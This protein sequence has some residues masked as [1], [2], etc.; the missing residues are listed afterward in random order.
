MLW[1]LSGLAGV[2]ETRSAESGAATATWHAPARIRN[3]EFFEM[4]LAVDAHERIDELVVS[5]D[6]A[7]WEDFTINTFFPAAS[8][9]T[10]EDGRL[11]LTFGPVERGGTFEM[12]VDAQIN[13][14]ML[15]RNEGAVVVSDGDDRLL[16]IPVVIE[17]LP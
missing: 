9:E 14:D 4:R 17:V 1:A 13:P 6:L 16:E 8:E 2:E 5:I 15:W 10:T 11:R 3:G 7:L 12:K